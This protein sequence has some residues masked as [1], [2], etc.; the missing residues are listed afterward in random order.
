[1]VRLSALLFSVVCLACL[2]AAGADAASSAAERE[3]YTISDEWQQDSLALASLYWSA[4]G[5]TCV[6]EYVSMTVVPDLPG[7]RWGEADIGA[8]EDTA[9]GYETSILIEDDMAIR[10]WRMFCVL[11]LHEWGHLIG[12]DH[13]ENPKS[14]MYSQQNPWQKKFKA[15]CAREQIV[16]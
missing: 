12:R 1:M 16:R 6:D 5:R 11:V 14:I 2:L 10:G 15:P 9:I 8:C 4:R 7:N 13:S 3:S